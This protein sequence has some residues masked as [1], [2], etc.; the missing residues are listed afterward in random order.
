MDSGARGLFVATSARYPAPEPKVQ[1]AGAKMPEE[2]KVAER[3][4]GVYRLNESDESV[5]DDKVL[6]PYRK[7][8]VVEKVWEE[9]V[10]TWE[11]ALAA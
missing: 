6:G 3:S 1:G 4:N 8:G 5:L 11:R 10:K 7:D 9:T 2:L